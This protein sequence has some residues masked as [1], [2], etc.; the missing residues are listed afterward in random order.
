[1]KSD[2]AGMSAPS[3]QQ[4]RDQQVQMEPRC[5]QQIASSS[6]NRIASPAVQPRADQ[7]EHPQAPGSRTRILEAVRYCCGWQNIQTICGKNG[8]YMTVS[9]IQYHSDND[10]LLW[11]K[12]NLNTVTY[13][14][15][16]KRVWGRE[17]AFSMQLVDHSTE[18]E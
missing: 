7:R 2:S 6:S 11:M 17:L 3:C 15:F 14:I 13:S 18:C 4:P 16:C 9:E 1:M 10:I 8:A 5:H 12:L